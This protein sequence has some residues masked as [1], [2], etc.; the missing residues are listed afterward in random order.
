MSNV[1]DIERLAE[2]PITDEF[3]NLLFGHGTGVSHDVFIEKESGQIIFV[4]SRFLVWEEKIKIGFNGSIKKIIPVISGTVFVPV[5]N[6][7]QIVRYIDKYLN[8]GKSDVEKLVQDIQDSIDIGIVKVEDTDNVMF[9][10][11]K[12]LSEKYL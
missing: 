11:I 7:F 2:M 5:N 10:T 9:G 12:K 6:A 1:I 8:G 4:K 3:A